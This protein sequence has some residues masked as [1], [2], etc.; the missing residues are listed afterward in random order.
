M[1][2]F[3]LKTTA[4][5]E[6]YGEGP[7]AIDCALANIDEARA[8][9]LISMRT[10]FAET[11]AAFP[12]LV[13]LTFA[14]AGTSFHKMMHLP[15]AFEDVCVSIEVEGEDGGVVPEDVAKHLER[16]TP[17]RTEVDRLV[18]FEDGVYW[19]CFEKNGD[20]EIETAMIAWAAIEKLAGIEY[21]RAVSL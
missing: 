7:D 3:I 21:A 17:A 16:V 4:A 1:A 14:D 19:T 10:K 8:S 11:K 6:F 9:K 15:D 13:S 12:D 5:N 20:V 18:L 2:L